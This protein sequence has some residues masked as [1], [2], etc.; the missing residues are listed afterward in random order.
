MGKFDRIRTAVFPAK[1]SRLLRCSFLILSGMLLHTGIQPAAM[2]QAA[3][4][5]EVSAVPAQVVPVIKDIGP[6][7]DSVQL[8]RPPI[9]PGGTDG[10]LRFISQQLKYPALAAR[11]RVEGKVLISFWVDERGHP[12]GFGILKGLGAGLDEEALRILRLMPDWQPALID[13]HPTLLQMRI[14]VFFRVAP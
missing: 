13:G 5:A 10:L 6:E 12:Y 11:N 1:A 2:A 4:R 3:G 8:N 7:T 9:F 14:P